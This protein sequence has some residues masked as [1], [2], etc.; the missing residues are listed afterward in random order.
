MVWRGGDVGGV[1][2]RFQASYNVMTHS[3]NHKDV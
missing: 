2:G 3:S 1:L